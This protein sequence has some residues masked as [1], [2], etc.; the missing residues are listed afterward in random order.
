MPPK[1]KASA[2]DGKGTKTGKP[3]SPDYIGVENLA[4]TLAAMAV[5]EKPNQ[6]LKETLTGG[7]GLRKSTG[8]QYADKLDEVI[9]LYGWPSELKYSRPPKIWTIED[10]KAIRPQHTDM[11]TRYKTVIK[12][13]CRNELTPMLKKFYNA[14]GT[15]PSGKNAD[16]A[17]KF[18]LSLWWKYQNKTTEDLTGDDSDKDEPAECMQPAGPTAAGGATTSSGGGAATPVAEAV[19]V[20]FGA[21]EFDSGT[22]AAHAHAFDIPAA[23]AATEGGGEDDDD[24]AMGGGGAGTPS[25]NGGL[26]GATNGAKAAAALH[27]KRAA[28][29]KMAGGTEK[30]KVAAE[31]PEEWDGGPIFFV[32]KTLGPLGKKLAFLL[33]APEK[34]TDPSDPVAEAPRGQTRDSFKAKE[35]AETKRKR[36]EQGGG[37]G[38][39]MT[40]AVARE[41]IILCEEE[42]LRQATFANA[43]AAWDSDFALIKFDL[44]LAK[45]TGDEDELRTCM[46]QLAALKKKKPVM[47][48]EEH[49]AP[50]SG[51]APASGPAPASGTAPATPP[52][53][54]GEGEG[55][56]AAKDSEAGGA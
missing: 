12:K 4:V 39:G 54:G 33:P 18:V 27:K 7:E 42:S 48:T 41:R 52:N 3:P 34:V 19:E 53:S 20:G 17:L 56:D 50:A 15:M 31:P 1:A 11:W 51:T 43:Q 16:D 10:S 6:T 14:D 24:D 5:G 23:A 8:E 35:S 49:A 9:A 37:I 47:P 2:K 46:A 45:E 40:K 44:Q 26:G 28:R 55:S 38:G 30:K 29:A 36:E 32:W 25:V 22:F 21:D 13:I